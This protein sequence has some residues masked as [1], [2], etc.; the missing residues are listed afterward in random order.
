MQNATAIG[1]GAQVSANNSLVLGAGA[2]VGIGNS[3][4][5]NKLEITQGTTGNSGLRFTNL[6]SAITATQST[7][8]FLTVNSS[9]DVVLALVGGSKGA[10]RQAA[11][12]SS[13]SEGWS[14]LAD[15]NLQNTNSGGVV[16]G[17]GL[18]KT[19]NGYKLYVEDGIL[20]EKVKVALKSTAEWSDYVFSPTYRLAPLAEVAS[21]VKSNKHLPGIPSA[22]EV[23]RDGM[24]VRDMNAKLLSKIEELTLYLIN[25]KEE[26][27]VLKKQ[28]KDLKKHTSHLE[29]KINKVSK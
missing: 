8:Q 27:N 15:G 4:P 16:I 5:A 2:N 29:K 1:Y 23:V 21:Y 9:G 24:D 3:A 26:V 12:D 13:V 10:F 7:N 18:S 25:L 20:T 22:E 11:A 19:P 17:Q 28:N 6:T 14:L